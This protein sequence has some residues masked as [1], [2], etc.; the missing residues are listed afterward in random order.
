MS[1]LT[2]SV[3]SKR[4]Y[5]QNTNIKWRSYSQD[6]FNEARR[7]NK[8]IYIFIYA[9]WCKWCLKFEVE[10]LETAAIRRRL[11][12]NFVPVAV[13]YD[14]QKNWQNSWE[15]KWCPRVYC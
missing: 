4:V 12:N 13:N 9:D 8:P 10:T 2:V 14:K 6:V 1:A 7:R 15:P 3:A 5:M 11:N